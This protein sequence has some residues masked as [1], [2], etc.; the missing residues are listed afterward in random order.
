M[1]ETDIADSKFGRSYNEQ[2]A[3][4]Y[5]YVNGQSWSGRLLVLQH[6]RD[7]NRKKGCSS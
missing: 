1:A 2:T 5:R 4:Q 3:W 7:E 6:E